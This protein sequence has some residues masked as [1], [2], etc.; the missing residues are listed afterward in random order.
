MRFLLFLLLLLPSADAAVALVTKSS[1]GASRTAATSFTDT[2]AASTVG[3][4]LLLVPVS[5]SSSFDPATATC[6]DTVG[7]V[8]TGNLWVHTPS[9]LVA[10]VNGIVFWYAY[11]SA[12][13]ALVTGSTHVVTC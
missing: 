4:T 10:T 12:S 5:A 7:G 6:S 1:T 13:G 11:H 3:A 9:H 8:A 2:F